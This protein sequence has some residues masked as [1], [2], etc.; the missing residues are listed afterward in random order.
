[1]PAKVRTHPY[2]ERFLIQPKGL[3]QVG[4]SA[5]EQ[6]LIVIHVNRGNRRR[7]RQVPGM[8]TAGAADKDQFDALTRANR[9]TSRLQLHDR[10]RAA[11]KEP[12]ELAY[13]FFAIGIGIGLGD[14][15]RLITALSLALVVLVIAISRL[16]RGHGA[17]FNLHL[18]V[19]S[20][21]PSKVDLEAISDTLRSHTVQSRLMRTDENKKSLEA[22]FLVEFRNSAQFMAAK[23]ALQ[24][25]SDNIEITFLDNK[26]IG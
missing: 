7:F 22:S 10:F 11:I 19:A 20:S 3:Q 13:L 6:L 9:F 16:M 4:S 17:D 26:G 23:K 25:L 12:E 18:T 5:Q 24:A 21:N 8:Y 2:E 14:N 15:Q 1:M